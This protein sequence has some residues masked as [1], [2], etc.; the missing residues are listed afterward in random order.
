MEHFGENDIP[1]KKVK[2]TPEKS[3]I[4]LTGDSD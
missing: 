2:K 3:M 1:S 4:D